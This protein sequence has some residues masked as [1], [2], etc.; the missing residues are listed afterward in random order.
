MKDKIRIWSA[1]TLILAVTFLNLQ[2]AFLFLAAPWNF[3]PGF[4]LSGQAGDAMIRGLGLLFVMWNV[5]YVIA[6]LHPV[7]HR[8]SLIE[9]VVMQLIGAVGETLL[10]LTLGGT[11]LALTG[12]VTRFIIFDSGGLFVLIIALLIVY[13]I[14]LQENKTAA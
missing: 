4:E 2:C 3:S 6:L 13:K 9:A 14:P 8:T 1:R 5:P 10:L 12:T 7:K 11:H